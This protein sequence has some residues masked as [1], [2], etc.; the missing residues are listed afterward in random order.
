MRLTIYTDGGSR[1]NPGPAAFAVVVTR[2]DK[3]V[4]EYA[5]YIGRTTNN[6]AEYQGAIA[7]LKEAADMGAD[8]VEVVS[9]SEL[10]VRQVNGQYAC[11]AA[12]LQPYLEEIRKL[13]KKFS[14][15]TFS[16][17]RRGHP[18]VSRA[19]A[20]LNQE[21]DIMHDLMPRGKPNP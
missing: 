19:D 12:N 7:A 16:N 20:L 10:M 2:D 3:V 14:K 18:M 15:V 13:S 6:V 11:R 9:D 4:K 21:Q 17:V 5:R 1:G 8:E